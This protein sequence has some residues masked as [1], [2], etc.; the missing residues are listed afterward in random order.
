M[1]GAHAREDG[2]GREADSSSRPPPS[3]SP[4]PTP[5]NRPTESAGG[6]NVND[7]ALAA[8]EIASVTLSALIAEWVVLALADSGA[9]LINTAVGLL[10]FAF[11][12]LSKGVRGETARDLGFRLDN[13]PRALRLLALPTLAMTAL[14]LLAGAL[15][16]SIN[17]SRWRGGWAFVGVPAFGLAWGLV[18]Q[19]ALQA[20]INRRAQIVCGRGAR[21]V[22]LVSAVFALAHFPNPALTAFTFAGGLVW[23]AVYQ[24][25]P[26]LL[27]L[28]VS[29]AL[30][31]WVLVSTLPP[32]LLGG[33]RVGY[34]YFV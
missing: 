5:V 31:T 10:A 33:L 32:H 26:N 21:S 34:K 9:R 2:G 16:G 25:A 18:Q 14:L 19:Y 12:L 7:R 20:F 1:T 13:F 8:W 30:M 24:R 29:H 11:M 17:F 28:A 22:L 6:A 4:A 15:A 23:A 27:A 3:L